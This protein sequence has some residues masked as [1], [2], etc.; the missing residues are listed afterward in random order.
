MP[1]GRYSPRDEYAIRELRSDYEA[2]DVS[3]RIRLLTDLLADSR[4]WIPFE[5]AFLA[6]TNPSPL[7]RWKADG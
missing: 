4:P 6:A 1:L 2:A 7:V 5:L 3:G